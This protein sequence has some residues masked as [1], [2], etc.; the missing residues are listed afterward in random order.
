MRKPQIAQMTQIFLG[1]QDF[2]GSG[3]KRDG[4][5]VTFHGL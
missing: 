2:V 5:L 3:V 1:L 4:P